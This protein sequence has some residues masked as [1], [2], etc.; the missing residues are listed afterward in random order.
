M[1]HSPSSKHSCVLRLVLLVLLGPSLAA[2]ADPPAK[3][4]VSLPFANL[5]IPRLEKRPVIDDFLTMEPLQNQSSVPCQMALLTSREKFARSVSLARLSP[6]STVKLAWFDTLPEYLV[7]C[8][9]AVI[10][11]GTSP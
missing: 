5:H 9:V 2:L 11:H 1:P 6:A 7:N 10:E 4:K 3:D 8:Q